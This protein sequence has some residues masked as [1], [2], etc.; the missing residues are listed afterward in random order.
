MWAVDNLPHAGPRRNR[1]GSN[2]GAPVNSLTPATLARTGLP[3]ELT[4]SPKRIEGY[5]A[6]GRQNTAPRRPRQRKRPPRDTGGHPHCRLCRG[7]ARPRD[8]LM[9]LNRIDPVVRCRVPAAVCALSQHRE[10][11]G[12]DSESHRKQ[13]REI[14]Q[15]PRYSHCAPHRDAPFC[16]RD[17]QEEWPPRG[18]GVTIDLALSTAGVAKVHVVRRP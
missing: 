2:P 18:S 17:R 11:H 6:T 14:N 13:H 9:V 15:K 10:T 1:H 3:A 4:A 5:V 16:K 8:A 12:D 7:R